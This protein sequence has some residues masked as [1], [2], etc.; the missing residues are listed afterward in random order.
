MEEKPSYYSILTADIRYDKNLSANEKILYSEITALM[1][2]N[3][4]CWATNKYFAELYN[5]SKETV[6]RWIKNLNNLGHICVQVV[7]DVRTNEVIERT[8]TL[9][10]IEIIKSIGID[11]NVN[12]PPL[13]IINTPPLKNVKENNT[14]NNN[15]SINNIYSEVLDYLNEK[16]ETRYR[17]VESNF[18]HIKARMNEGFKIEDFKVVIDKKCKEW[19]G[20]EFEKY[21]TPETLFRP[22]NFE[23]YLNQKIIKPKQEFEQ[24]Q[25]TKEDFENIFD[26]LDDLDLD[27]ALEEL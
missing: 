17:N 27:K 21:L 23:K 14:S 26:N 22:S 4:V 25:Y 16:A 6:S 18:K 15:T 2:K 3:G 10:T 12:T 9:P 7:R 24:R 5:V 1:G 19:K 11:E 8:I 13:K 20:T